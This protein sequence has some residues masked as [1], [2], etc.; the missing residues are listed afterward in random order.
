MTGFHLL[1]IGWTR[2]GVPT[3][4]EAGCSAKRPVFVLRIET[5]LQSCD[6]S[7]RHR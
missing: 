6:R 2:C 5:L 1:V 4:V 3:T 7:L